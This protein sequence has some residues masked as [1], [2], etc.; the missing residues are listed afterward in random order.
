MPESIHGQPIWHG[1]TVPVLQTCLC[2]DRQY[3]RQT[4]DSPVSRFSPV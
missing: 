1:P 3:L 4:H 2:S